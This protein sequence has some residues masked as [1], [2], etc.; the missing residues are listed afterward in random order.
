VQIDVRK[1]SATSAA[2]PPPSPEASLNLR[3]RRPSPWCRSPRSLRDP[4]SPIPVRSI[5]EIL[6]GAAK[7]VCGDAEGTVLLAEPELARRETA[8]LEAAKAGQSCAGNCL[9]LTSCA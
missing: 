2:S 5:A 1:P 6:Q 4:G 9:S 3:S 8:K 7:P